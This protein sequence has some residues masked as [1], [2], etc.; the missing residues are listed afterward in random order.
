MIRGARGEGS[1]VTADGEARVLYT[2]R[3]LAEA[4]QAMGKSVLAVAQGFADGDSGIGDMAALLQAGMEAA[5]HEGRE[6]GRRVSLNDAFAVMDAVGFAAVAT[7]VMEAVSDVL[8]YEPA[9]DASSNNED[10]DPNR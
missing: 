6:G 10:D 5:R 2:N 4:E 1:I 9:E 7:V 8:S 3:A